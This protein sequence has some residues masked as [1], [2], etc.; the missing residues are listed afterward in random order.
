MLNQLFNNRW[1][2]GDEGFQNHRTLITSI[3]RDR[4]HTAAERRFNKLFKRVR[5]WIEHTFGLLKKMFP[6]LLIVI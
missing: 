4:V 1:L 6:I 2:I 3:R 5:V